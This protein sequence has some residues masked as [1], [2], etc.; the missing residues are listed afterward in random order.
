MAE[1]YEYALMAGAAYVTNRHRNNWIPTPQGWTDLSSSGGYQY[2][3][4]TGFEAT[5]F[6]KGNEVVIA[7]AGTDQQL[8]WY[9]NVGMGLGFFGLGQ[10]KQAASFYAKM[11]AQYGDSITY[12]FTGHSLG[13]GIAAL[14]GVFFNKPAETFDPAPF[15]QTANNDTRTILRN[16]LA[17]LTGASGQSLLSPALASALDSFWSSLT[18]NGEGAGIQ[19]GS[20]GGTPR[21]ETWR[22]AA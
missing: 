13:G 16:Y 15:R 9:T 6:R 18:A 17:D 11:Y 8:D 20:R 14:M 4:T 21:N 2:D 7:F 22:V 12:T 19:P 3:Q 1:T 10:L 5:A